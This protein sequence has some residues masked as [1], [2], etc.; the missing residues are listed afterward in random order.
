[1]P[2]KKRNE[3]I[4]N[5]HPTSIFDILYRLRIRF[6]YQDTEIFLKAPQDIK[7]ENFTK[8]NNNLL[9]ILDQS[10]QVLELLTARYLG[11]KTFESIVKE[12]E[13]VTKNIEKK[14][15]AKRWEL[16]KNMW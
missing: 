12:Q 4:Q 6:N 8:F 11:K 14:P 2:P 3:I 5:L 7:Q 15:F 1:M 16:N 10:A 13:K 9:T